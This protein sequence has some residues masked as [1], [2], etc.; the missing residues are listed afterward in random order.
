MQISLQFLV[1]ALVRL[2]LTTPVFFLYRVPRKKCKLGLLDTLAF[3]RAKFRASRALIK[4]ALDSNYTLHAPN[5]DFYK[6]VHTLWHSQD[7]QYCCRHFFSAERE[8]FYAFAWLDRSAKENTSH[9]VCV[10]LAK[11]ILLVFLFLR[12]SSL[13]VSN[14][15]CTYG[16]FAS[17]G[18]HTHDDANFRLLRTFLRTRADVR[19]VARPR[20][21]FS[22][23]RT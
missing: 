1:S 6:V 20:I 14:S 9:F 22:S 19:I 5:N 12:K 8:G 23:M 15:P 11:N 10:C 4:N 3:F 16:N 2:F 18:S 13:E 21:I 17:L 7:N